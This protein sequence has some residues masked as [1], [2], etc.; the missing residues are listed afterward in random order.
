[1]QRPLS[2][3]EVTDSELQEKWRLA[4]ERKRYHNRI[5]S[6]RARDLLKKEVAEGNPKAI[7]QLHH[8][9]KLS[10]ARSVKANAKKSAQKAVEM[11]LLILFKEFCDQIAQID[12]ELIEKTLTSEQ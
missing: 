7:A 8:R 2:K 10:R 3:K 12:L 5:S 4:K 11:R 6:Q 1:M 9:N